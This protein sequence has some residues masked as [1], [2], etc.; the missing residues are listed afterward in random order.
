LIQRLPVSESAHERALA[1][2]QA[3]GVEPDPPLLRSLALASLSHYE[4]ETAQ[5]FGEQ[6]RDC[7]ERE[8]DDVLLAQS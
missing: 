8:S 2:A 6:L 4:F 5:Q 7:G 1:L 3:L